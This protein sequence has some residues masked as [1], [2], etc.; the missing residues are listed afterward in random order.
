MNGSE[1]NDPL[2]QLLQADPMPLERLPAADLARLR[3]RVFEVGVPMTNQNRRRLP[4]FRLAGGG[5]AVALVVALAILAMPHGLA[6]GI[7]ATPPASQPATVG[8]T[9]TSGGDIA[10]CVEQYSPQ[11]IAHRSIAFDGTVT[12]IQS[13]EVTL[14]VNVAYRGVTAGAS[15]TLTATGMTGTA[16]TSAGGP[17]LSVGS[18]YLVAGEDHFAWPC[19]YTQPY[20]PAVAAI[21]AAAFGA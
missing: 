11:T 8:P 19:G 21:W 20:D 3:A 14:R 12:A 7:S 5:L 17:T 9:A 18:R 6:P 16:I 10:M 13:D 15:V 1:E 2:D 4:A